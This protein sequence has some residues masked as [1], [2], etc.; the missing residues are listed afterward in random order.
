MESDEPAPGLFST[1]TD[2]PSSLLTVSAS[3]RKHMSVPPPAPYPT[4]SWM[5]RLGKSSAAAEGADKVRK[6]APTSPAANFPR[7][8]IPFRFID[9]SPLLVVMR[10]HDNLKSSFI[11]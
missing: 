2:C 8:E 5:G 7:M 1:T 11:D 3:A 9:L 4:T 10:S 6:P